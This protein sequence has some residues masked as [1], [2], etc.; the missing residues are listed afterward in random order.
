MRKPRVEYRVTLIM[1]GTP[2]E[3]KAARESV[4]R[5]L[6]TAYLRKAAQ[7][8]RAVVGNTRTRSRTA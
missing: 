1:A 3:D 2:E 6:M 7:E 4:G 8:S 5:L